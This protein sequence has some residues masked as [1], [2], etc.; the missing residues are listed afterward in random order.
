MKDLSI[1]GNKLRTKLA[2]IRSTL[3][4]LLGNSV[5]G[6]RRDSWG[7]LHCL[8]PLFDWFYLVYVIYS[9]RQ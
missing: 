8:G 1:P 5:S 4:V 7:W 3:T 9:S 6:E 2:L